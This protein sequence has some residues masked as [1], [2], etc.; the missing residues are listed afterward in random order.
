MNDM[1]DIMIFIACFTHSRT[2]YLRP[3]ARKFAALLLL[4]PSPEDA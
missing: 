3:D 4:P 2:V 1:T